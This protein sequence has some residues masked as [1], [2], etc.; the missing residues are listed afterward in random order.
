MIVHR[1]A[2][3]AVFRPDKMGK[4]DLVRGEQMSA[5]LNCFEPG[6]EH[7]AHTHAGQDKMYLVLEGSGDFT[8]GVEHSTLWPGDIVFAAAGVSHSVR[9]T[10]QNRLVVLVTFAP[11]PPAKS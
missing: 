3:H 1:A 7:A 5:G 10:G 4:V 11:P 9:N 6:Q 2:A 8:V